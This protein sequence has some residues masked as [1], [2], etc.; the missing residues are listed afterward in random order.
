MEETSY[1]LDLV[2]K[3]DKPVVHD[4]LDAAVDRDERRRPAQH[5]QRRRDRRRSGRRADAACWCASTTTSTRRTTSSRRTPPTSRPSRSGEAGLVGA[6]LFGKNTWY[7]TPAQVHTTKSEFA[8]AG[9]R[10]RCRASTSST[11]TPTCRPTSSPSAVAN[12]AKGLVIAGVGDGNMTA[13]ALE[14]VKAAVAQGRRRRALLAHQR[15]HH[16]PQHRA[17]RRPA[18]HRRLDGAQSGEGARAAPARAAQDDG[19]EEDP[20]TTSTATDSTSPAGRE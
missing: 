9:V 1:F 11:R 15:R 20:E 3:S 19:S 13:P 14:A 5:L 2:V 18:R 16:P 10:R 7:R 6:T 17:Q 4:R 8:I 12:G